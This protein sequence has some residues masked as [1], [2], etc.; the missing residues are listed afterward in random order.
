MI[1][2]Y[3]TAVALLDGHKGMRSINEPGVRRYALEM[4]NCARETLEDFMRH[5]NYRKARIDNPL[6]DSSLMSNG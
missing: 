5:G 1:G 4:M 3:H 2:M 6:P